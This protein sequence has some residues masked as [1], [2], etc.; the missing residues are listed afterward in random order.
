MQ[1]FGLPQVFAQVSQAAFTAVAHNIVPAQFICHRDGFQLAENGRWIVQ[2]LMQ[3]LAA[4]W[5]ER[6][7]E[8]FQPVY[9]LDGRKKGLLRLSPVSF[10]LEPGCVN[11]QIFIDIGGQAH[12]IGQGSFELD[13]LHP[14]GYLLKTS[15][16]ACQERLICLPQRAWLRDDTIP[17]FVGEGQH[18]IDQVAPGRHQLII[19]ALE[20]LFPIPIR[21]FVF[22]HGSSEIVAQCIGVVP[23][24]RVQPPDRPMMR[25]ANLAAF[26]I[27]EFI[28]W[29]VIWKHQ[30]L[31]VGC[32]QPAVKPIADAK[33]FGR[34]GYRMKGDVVFTNKVK[35]L[36]LRIDPPIPP[37]V[38]IAY[39]QL[40]PFNRRRK[41]AND[42]FK[43]NIQTLA[44]PAFK[45][46]RN[47][48]IQ[49]AG[50]RCGLEA[51][52][53]NLAQRLAQHVGA[54]ITFPIAQEAL[55]WAFKRRE[56]EV[57]MFCRA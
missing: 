5:Q 4:E 40:G 32:P 34:P 17:I 43:P 49:V 45:R 31:W 33:Q 25:T 15:S 41:I 10:N 39:A 52:R 3:C 56:I 20:K 12:H 47:A 21:I 1:R 55:N 38:I 46:H 53:L 28:R 23:F 44:F 42:R 2:N 30:R 26:Q 6:R 57:V 54:P 35:R 50:D 13:P 7:E 18:T 51:D 11:I 48:P 24:Q 22:G 27:H 36:G 8:N 29:H 16:N 37:E 14:A 19:V 9:R